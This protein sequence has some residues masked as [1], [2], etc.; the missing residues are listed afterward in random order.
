MKE[1]GV[2]GQIKALCSI[3]GIEFKPVEEPGDATFEPP[4]KKIK[5]QI[6]VVRFLEE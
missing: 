3:D 6:A 1:Q 2:S 5:R 4:V